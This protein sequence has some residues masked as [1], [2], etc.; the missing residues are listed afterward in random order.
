MIEPKR[1]LALPDP[2]DDHYQEALEAFSR[3][4]REERTRI[5][6]QIGILG[7]DGKLAPAY[8]DDASAAGDE[9]AVIG[10]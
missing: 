6:Q 2:Y 8:A 3:R 5:L 1:T 7:P 9:G 10:S 4:P